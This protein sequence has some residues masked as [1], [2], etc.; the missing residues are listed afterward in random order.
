[1]RNVN[2]VSRRPAQGWTL[3]LLAALTLPTYAD[4]P[5]ATGWAPVLDSLTAASRAESELRD[6]VERFGEDLQAV[7]RRFDAEGSPSR[8]AALRSFYEA[9][10][11][12]LDAMGFEALG[13]EGRLDWLLLSNRIASH[14]LRLEREEQR[15]AETAPLVPFADAVFA[16][17]DALRDSQ[18]AKP[19]DA[20]ATLDELTRT[21]AATRQALERGLAATAEDQGAR[22]ETTPTVAY[23][24][25]QRVESLRQTLSEWFTFY[26][27][28]D[29][30][31]TWWAREPHTKA[32]AAL[33]DYVDFL[34]QRIVG[35]KE[36]EDPP[37][38]GDPIGREALLEDLALE[39]IPYT[40]EELLAIG[41]REFAWC[42]REMLKAS[43]E[44]GFG[45]DWHAAL[46]HV[47]TLHVEPGRQPALIRE[48]GLEAV[49]FLEER[50][51]V[52]LPELAKDDWRIEMISPE[53]Q[54]LNPFFFFNDDAIWVSFPTASMTHE[55]KLMSLRGNNIHFSRA[56][57]HHE[58]IPGHHLQLFMASR[59]NAHRQLFYT[60]FWIEGW[61]LYW[62]MVLWDQGFHAT[63]ADRVGALFWRM[64]RAARIVFSLKFH[65]GEWTPQQAIDF[66]VD[67]VGHER[68][69]ATAEVRRSFAGNYSP[70][71]QLAYM[72]GALQFRA[73]AA[74]L[75]GPDK[76]SARD[77]HDAVLR[78][79][80]MP[81]ELVRARLTGQELRRGFRT[82]WRFAGEP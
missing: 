63:P 47:K 16:L 9:W 40:P 4:P 74:E 10:R 77:F 51:L 37:I 52:T 14:L 82:S 48:L 64:H 60:P 8:R 12:A 76:L 79:G 55:Q 67:R 71:Y 28:Y 81:V 46:E 45:D 36:G 42:D 62:E 11:G 66:L 38:V 6:V 43:R 44:L 35:E 49:A 18:P 19:E 13:Q 59:Y 34:R 7:R 53:A 25:V 29:P 24:A 2:H 73:L 78:G 3:I 58:L 72:I 70:L 30:L 31:F 26:D 32:D 20:A 80:T 68:D 65:L 33:G 50:R 39:M 56:T 21:V 75:V 23:R 15:A 57:V 27:G 17:H 54:K 22:I 1:M 41:E 5:D 61:A 69:N